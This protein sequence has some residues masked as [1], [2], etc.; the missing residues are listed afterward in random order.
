MN[1]TGITRIP[2][3]EKNLD[4]IIGMAHAKDILKLNG[5]NVPIKEMM[6]PILK[7]DGKMRADDVLRK[8]QR[9]NTHLAIVK[10]DGKTLGLVSMEDLIEEI[11][12]EIEDEHD[13]K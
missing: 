4:G 2:V 6:R 9:E 7:V 8:M 10:N 12:G 13:P 1:E 3:Y 11:V 5:E